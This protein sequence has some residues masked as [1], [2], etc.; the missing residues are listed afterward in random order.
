MAED[1][2]EKT[3][4]RL[5]VPRLVRADGPILMGG[6]RTWHALV[7]NQAL[8][9]EYHTRV[10]MLSLRDQREEEKHTCQQVRP[11]AARTLCLS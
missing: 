10:N 7:Q 6:G 1:P 8:L 4:H 11:L 5:L 9:R 2:V 3:D